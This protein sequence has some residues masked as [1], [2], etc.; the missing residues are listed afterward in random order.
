MV[1]ASWQLS[2]DSAKK[3]VDRFVGFLWKCVFPVEPLLKT[4]K[5]SDFFSDIE[6]ARY[7]IG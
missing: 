3:A 1:N 2:P 5:D 6:S 4:S 7:A